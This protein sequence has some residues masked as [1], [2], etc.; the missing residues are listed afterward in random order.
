MTAVVGL[1]AAEV[2]AGLYA[3]A[4][5]RRERE[6][7]GRAVPRE[8]AA[9]EKRLAAEWSVLSNDVA[10]ATSLSANVRDL[11]AQ[12]TAMPTLGVG[13]VAALLGTNRRW[14]QRHAADLG[15]QRIANRWLF[16]ERD[17]A[18]VRNQL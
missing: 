2:R 4:S 10:T 1:S 11:K 17:I 18:K 6:L 15:G 7:G 5:L 16:N 13:E 12:G 9:L 8:V 14:V 3:C